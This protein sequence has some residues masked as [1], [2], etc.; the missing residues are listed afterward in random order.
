MKYPKPI[1]NLIDKL[2]RLPSVGPKTAERY[3]FY[4]LNRDRKEL[5]E[6]A[7]A[8]NELKEKTVVCRTCFQIAESNPC[9]ICSDNKRDQRQICIVAD[10]KA[11]AVIEATGHYNG[12]YQVLGGELDPVKGVK[13]ERLNIKPLLERLK[14]SGANEVILALNPTIEG[15]TT[16]MYLSKLLKDQ[17]KGKLRITRIARGLPMGADLEY[18][19]EITIGNALKYRNEL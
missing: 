1:Q 14:K 11:L 12:Y 2:S 5:N 10:T 13:P 3:V 17:F 8:I 7:Q 9:P 15:E 18:A 16:S 19:D 4:L 6:L